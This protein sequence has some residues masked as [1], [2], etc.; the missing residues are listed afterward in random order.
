MS[1]PLLHHG[2]NLAAARARFG[3]GDWL[4]LST[5]INPVPW[6]IPEDLRPDLGVLPAPDALAALEAAAAAHFGVAPAQLCAVP[7][8]EMGLRLLG[9]LLG[10]RACHVV[11]GYRTHGAVFADSMPIAAG[12]PVPGNATLIFANPGNPCGT[13][14]SRGDIQALLHS[15]TLAGGWLVVDEAF[16]DPHPSASVAP[17]V[18]DRRRLI[19]FRSFGKFF[20][21]AGLRLGFVLG[22]RSVLSR[23]RR[24]LGD[25]PID[26][27]ALAIATAAY[28][29]GPWIDAVRI[30]LP[31]RAAALDGVLVAHGL[32]PSGR[33]PLFRLIEHDS[34]PMMFDRLARAH[35]LVRPFDYAP[36]WLRFGI[37]NGEDA[38][39]RL[40]EA[41]GNV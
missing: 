2:G 34:A 33:S 32:E 37:P 20:G 7:G 40:D 11:P 39:R 5:G 15:R 1:D 9:M 38:L 36:R 25:W 3:D 14:H 4:D 16:A 13:L 41:L 27:T 8:S 22:P 18:D 17:L 31:Q 23:Y 19:V 24:V 35:I 30:A 6:Q 26:T 28:R 10:G 12:E 29:D 21:L